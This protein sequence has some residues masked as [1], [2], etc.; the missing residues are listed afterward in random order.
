MKRIIFLSLLISSPSFAGCPDSLP[1]CSSE[2]V[3]EMIMRNANNP[4]PIYEPPM[5]ETEHYYQFRSQ[6]GSISRAWARRLDR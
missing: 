6:D 2:Y 5:P 4:T 3:S 1:N